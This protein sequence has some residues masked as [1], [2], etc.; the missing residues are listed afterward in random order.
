MEWHEHKRGVSYTVRNRDSSTSCHSQLTG[1][2][3]V[4][5]SQLENNIRKVKKCSSAA[6][7]ANYT[8][9]KQQFEIAWFDQWNRKLRNGPLMRYRF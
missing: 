1:R 2:R 4:A 7:T 5:E 8:L 6:P 9:G 3:F